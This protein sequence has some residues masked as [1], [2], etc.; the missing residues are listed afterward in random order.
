[1]R[2]SDT[3]HRPQF[4]L[5]YPGGGGGHRRAKTTVAHNKG[6]TEEVEIYTGRVGEEVA[7]GKMVRAHNY[8]GDLASD[9]WCTIAPIEGDWHLVAGEC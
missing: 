3:P 7:S 5:L 2:S 1:M 9:R 6:A 4:E 8:Y